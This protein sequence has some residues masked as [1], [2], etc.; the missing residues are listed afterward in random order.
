MLSKE[1]RN[2]F[3]NKSTI[4]IFFAAFFL[5]VGKWIFSYYFFDDEIGIRVIFENPSDGFFYFPYVKY[6]SSLDFN[7]SFDPEINNLK[8]ISVPL[9]GVLFHSIFFKI[10]GNYSFIILEFFFISAFLIIFYFIFQKFNFSKLMSINLAILLFIIPI[11][12]DFFEFSRISYLSNFS[13]FYNLRFQRPLVVALFFFIF[14]LFLISLS[15][16]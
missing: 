14:I 4:F 12:I 6:L 2:N 16:K 1:L 7:I 10:F 8:N 15:N 5:F 13:D 3:F 11:L 9:Y